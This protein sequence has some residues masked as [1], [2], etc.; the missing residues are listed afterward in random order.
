MSLSG[1]FFSTNFGPKQP[2]K[3]IKNLAMI[4]FMNALFDIGLQNFV[5]RILASK[6]SPELVDLQ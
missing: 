2:E 1:Q 4:V 5:P 6:M 3:L